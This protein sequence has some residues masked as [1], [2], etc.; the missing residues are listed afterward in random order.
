MKFVGL[1]RLTIFA[2]KCYTNFVVKLILFFATDGQVGLPM[3]SKKQISFVDRLGSLKECFFKLP[4]FSRLLHKSRLIFDGKTL[5]NTS[6]FGDEQTAKGMPVPK[7]TRLY[8]VFLVK[9]KN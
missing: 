7:N 3:G 9:P 2:R 1:K 5:Q 4:F 8:C 6:C